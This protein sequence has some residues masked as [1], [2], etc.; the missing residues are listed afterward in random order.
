MSD[1]MEV[2]QW[3]RLVSDDGGV[4]GADVDDEL[5]GRRL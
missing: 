4:R 3:D 5:D 1:R 2:A